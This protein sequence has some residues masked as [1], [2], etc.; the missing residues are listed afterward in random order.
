MTAKTILIQ[1]RMPEKLVRTI[2][3]LQEEGIYT[4]RTEVILDS[5]RRLVSAFQT[6]DPIKQSVARSLHGNA[7][8]GSFRDIA[9]EF[10]PEDIVLALTKAYKTNSIDA[11]IDE[12]RR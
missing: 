6:N 1:V 7:G 3:A 8:S 12:V 11:I 2:D 9:K 4:S 5:V 10:D